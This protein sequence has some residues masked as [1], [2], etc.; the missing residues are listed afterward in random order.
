VDGLYVAQYYT[1]L[2][3][4]LPMFPSCARLFAKALM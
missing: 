3:V 2:L 1:Q 4:A